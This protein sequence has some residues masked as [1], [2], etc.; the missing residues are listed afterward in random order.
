MSAPAPA[1]L[2]GGLPDRLAGW[3]LDVPRWRFLTWLLLV[4][5]VKTGMTD[6]APALLA[7][8][9]DPYRNPF[10]NPFEHYLFWSWL[11]PFVAHLIGAD[12]PWSFTLFYLVF[13]LAF[14]VLMVRWLFATLDERSARVALLVFA[15]LPVS[16]TSYY[17]IFTDSLTLFL[18]ACTLYLPRYPVA[19]ALLGVLLGMQHAEQAILGATGALVALAWAERR[20]YQGRYRWT[21]ALGLLIGAV[22]GKLV[23]VFLFKHWGIHINSGRWYWLRRGWKLMLRRFAYSWH[24][25]LFSTFAVGWLVVLAFVRRRA[26]EAV[27][28]ALVLLALLGLLPIS[29]DPTRVVAIVSFP[30]LA[31]MVL[32]NR[33]FLA[34]LSR[35]T[36]GLCV[37]LW[38]LVPWTFVWS[39]KPLVSAAAYDVMVMARKLFHTYADRDPRFPF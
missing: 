33:D 24:V 13:S 39:G 26:A 29:D 36:V 22:I 18:L 6:V 4:M 32:A 31:V 27:P 35:E 11:G 10:T 19:V 9:K 20:G 5:F 14:T 25:S 1:P 17:W 7:I 28:V 3:V 12:K 21:W 38:L 15:L 23:L 37:L 8:V 30:L 16:A 34:S 2:L